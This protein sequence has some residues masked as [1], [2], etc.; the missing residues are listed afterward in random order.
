LQRL[1]IIFRPFK[2]GDYIEAAGVAGTVQVIQIFNTELATPDNKIIIVP[3]SKVTGDNIVNYSTK[4]TRRV[5]MVFGIGYDDDIDKARDIITE[6][7][8]QDERVLKDPEMKI[9]VSELADSSVNFIARPWVNSGEDWGVYWE[10][11]E[12]L[13]KTVRCPGYQH[14]VP[15]ARYTCL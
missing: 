12:K 3:N 13:K 4:G 5:D 11:T 2:T 6:I 9:A 1:L 7:L 10:T 14:T 8:S 15:S